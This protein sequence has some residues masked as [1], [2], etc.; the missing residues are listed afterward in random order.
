MITRN[1][2]LVDYDTT[3]RK[4]YTDEQI[5]QVLKFRRYGLSMRE[6]STRLNIPLSSIRNILLREK[7]LYNDTSTEVSY[8]WVNREQARL[9]YGL[10]EKSFDYVKR[11][12]PE[13]HKKVN[14]T[15]YIH[16]NYIN[17]Y[18]YGK[19]AYKE[20]YSYEST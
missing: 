8:K 3:R 20:R 1:E 4:K 2:Y 16:V 17:D 10:S 12:Y 13:F 15:A 6:L 5:A 9:Q 14:Y 7:K 11:A 19:K 18:Y